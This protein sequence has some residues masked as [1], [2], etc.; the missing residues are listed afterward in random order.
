[1]ASPRPEL[2][3]HLQSPA[4]LRLMTTLTAVS[5]VEFATLRE[6]LDVADSVLSKHIGLLA[7]SAYVRSRKGVHAGRRTTWVSITAKGRKV[8]GQHVAALR[9]IIDGIE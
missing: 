7:G 9:E 5:E 8:L 4:R 1:M 2:D 3:P 6:A